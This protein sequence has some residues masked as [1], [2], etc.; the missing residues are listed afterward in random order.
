MSN[1]DLRAAL[2]YELSLAIDEWR[3]ELLNSV[4]YEEWR[5]REAAFIDANSDSSER[6]L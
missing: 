5:A 1:S 4:S 2:I 6:R 3:G